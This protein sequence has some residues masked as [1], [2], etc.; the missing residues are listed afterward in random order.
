MT[1]L[2]VCDLVG[3]DQVAVLPSVE[4]DTQQG[5]TLATH[6]RAVKKERTP[7]RAG[8]QVHQF[9]VKVR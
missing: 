3:E 8:P 5:E 9:V 2:E 6:S 7:N 1:E 4:M